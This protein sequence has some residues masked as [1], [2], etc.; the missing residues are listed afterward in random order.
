MRTQWYCF[1][2]TPYDPYTPLKKIRILRRGKRTE[3]NILPS[4]SKKEVEP[5]QFENVGHQI[6][7]HS[8]QEH[9]SVGAR[10][11]SES[12]LNKYICKA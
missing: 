3:R 11:L 1:K 2:V 12:V 7:R 9:T 4:I 5:S 6:K 8:Y 10:C